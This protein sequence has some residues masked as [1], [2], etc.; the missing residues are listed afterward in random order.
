MRAQ[1]NTCR[2][3]FCLVGID[4]WSENGI[5][6]LGII[7]YFWAA[8]ATTISEV[9][10]RAV[11]FSKVAHTGD[12][13]LKAT[14]SALASMG[15]GDF[16]PDAVNEAGENVIIDTV[17]S[18]L[19]K[20]V[21]DGASNVQKGLDTFETSICPAHVGQRSVLLYLSVDDINKVHRKTKGIAALFRRSP[22]GLSCLHRCQEKYGLPQTQP[23]RSVTTRWNSMYMQWE[24]F[25][26]Q[27][28]ALQ[29]F[30]VESLQLNMS[31]DE[32]GSTYKDFQLEL[33]DWRIIEHTVCCALLMVQTFSC[34]LS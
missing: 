11:P 12:E 27:Q 25:P 17:R 24:W 29:M 34:K 16:K 22:L 32:E 30:D 31:A 10:V 4:I 21:A 2:L 1:S 18:C 14:K 23:S 8:H 19:H 5:A 13:I 26:T 7:C 15:I 9:L 28:R 33:M 6:L 20:A 3:F